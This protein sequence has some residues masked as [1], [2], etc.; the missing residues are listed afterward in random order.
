LTTDFRDVE[1][2]LL[3]EYIH[4]YS[5]GSAMAARRLAMAEAMRKRK[6]ITG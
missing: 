4:G 3:S 1:R 5:I 6:E 2:F